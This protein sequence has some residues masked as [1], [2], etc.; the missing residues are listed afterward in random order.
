MGSNLSPNY[1]DLSF[2]VGS[3]QSLHNNTGIINRSGYNHFLSILSCY[4]FTSRFCIWRMLFP[5]AMWG[6]LVLVRTDVS[7]KCV[8]SIFRVEKSA[9]EEE[10]Q[11]LTSKPRI[12]YPEDG[13]GIFLRNIGCHKTYTAPHPRRQYCSVTSTKNSSR[14][15]WCTIRLLYT[16][17]RSSCRKRSCIYGHLA[18]SPAYICKSLHCSNLF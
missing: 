8:T 9:S 4:S 18:F 7:E 6:R 5:S 2:Y 16:T 1:Y 3:P 13:G 10:S 17:R 12:C 11:Q 14:E 15:Y